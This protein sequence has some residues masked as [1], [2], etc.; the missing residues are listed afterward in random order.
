[1]L[2]TVNELCTMMKVTRTTIDNWRKEGMP[3][4]KF[5]RMVRFD[6]EEIMEWLNA[7]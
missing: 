2:I 6:K 7:K 5:G 3:V 1:M 4:K